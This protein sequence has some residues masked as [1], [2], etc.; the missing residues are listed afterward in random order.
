VLALLE[1]EAGHWGQAHAAATEAV[2]IAVQSGRETIEVVAASAL[3]MVE[4]VLGRVLPARRILEDALA[5]AVRTGRGGRAPRYGLGL[6]ELSLGDYGAAWAWLEPAIERILPLGL[7]EPSAQVS[8]GVEALAQ[9]GRAEEASRLL[10][11]FEEPARRLGRTWSLAAAARGHGLLLAAEG[12]LVGAEVALEEAVAIGE[13]LPRPL[14]RARSLLALGTVQRRLRRKQAARLTLGR[15]LEVF[16]ELGAPVWAERARRESG[17]IGGRVSYARELSAT[18]EQIAELVRLGRSNK[19]IAGALHL[20]VKTVEWN[21]SKI[22]RKLGVHS[23][24]ELSAA[25]HREE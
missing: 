12:E 19:E 3:G 5:L 11:A 2:E 20:S 15:A 7:T 21:L 4:G 6:L 23:R 22:Y 8:D 24:T 16:E 25:S 17:R 1:F 18:E 14:E 9:L 13:T 10:D